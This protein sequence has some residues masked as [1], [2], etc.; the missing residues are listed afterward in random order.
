MLAAAGELLRAGGVAGL[1]VEA[2]AARSGVAK[3]TIYR[4]WTDALAIGVDALL[5]QVD[6]VVPTPDTGTLADDLRHQLRAVAAFIASPPGRMLIS[7]VGKAQERADLTAMLRDRFFVPRRATTQVLLTRGID[8]GELP[9]S[10]D[11]DDVDLLVDLLVAPLYWRALTG[12]ETP[13]PDLADRVL[14]LL[15]PVLTIPP[16]VG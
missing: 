14:A 6:A 15:G 7:L 1:T 16:S 5:E 3:T 10:L 11:E 4:H 13:G 9:A 8:R 12:R 2:V